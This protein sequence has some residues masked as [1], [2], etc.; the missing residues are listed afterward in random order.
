MGFATMVGSSSPYLL[1]QVLLLPG[2]F[3]GI[4]TQ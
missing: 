3:P 2:Y 4:L 1:I